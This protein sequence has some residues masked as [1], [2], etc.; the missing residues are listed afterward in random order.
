MTGHAAPDGT[1]TVCQVKRS[2]CELILRVDRRRQDRARLFIELTAEGL[3]DFHS[4]L[5][6]RP[7]PHMRTRWG[8]DSAQVRD[9][10]G[11]E[12]PFPLPE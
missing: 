7:V 2:E 1:G 8:Y 6:E 9:P 12:L 3:G 11:N 10:D 4:E 5:T